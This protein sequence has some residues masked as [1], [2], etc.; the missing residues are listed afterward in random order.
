MSSCQY[1]NRDGKEGIWVP[2]SPKSKVRARGKGS[3]RIRVQSHQEKAW[4]R[5]DGYPVRRKDAQGK[6]QF[7]AGGVS[8]GLRPNIVFRG[9]TAPKTCLRDPW[10]RAPQVSSYR[11]TL[12]IQGM[13]ILS[14]KAEAITE[15]QSTNREIQRL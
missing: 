8:A 14:L 4:Q 12:T 10:H 5:L 3:V 7:L 1:L 9:A 15:L 6:T 13:V 11:A 2:D